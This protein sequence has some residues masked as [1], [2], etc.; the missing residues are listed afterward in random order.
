ML[1]GIEEE[2]ERENELMFLWLPL[3]WKGWVVFKLISVTVTYPL[4]DQVEVM[5]EMGNSL[6]TWSAH[7][8]FGGKL[9]FVKML[10]LLDISQM[11]LTLEIS[12][13]YSDLQ[14]F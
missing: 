7:I 5:R 13:T 11:H 2:S 10:A 8:R 1:F 9:M 6:S 3:C 4:S 12:I 14:N